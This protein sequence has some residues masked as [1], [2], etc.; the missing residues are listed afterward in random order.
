MFCGIEIAKKRYENRCVQSMRI[1]IESIELDRVQCVCVCLCVVFVDSLRVCEVAAGISA[2]DPLDKNLVT[3]R[4]H[5]D[6]QH[7]Y[8][9]NGSDLNRTS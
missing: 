5:C 1:I 3:L 2:L 8:S 9:I 4:P 7:Q 6:G